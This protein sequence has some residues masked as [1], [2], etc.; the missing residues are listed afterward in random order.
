MNS[1]LVFITVLC[2]TPVVAQA[3]AVAELHSEYRAMGAGNFDAAAGKALWYKK[4]VN[5]KDKKRRGCTSCHTEDPRKEGRHV[6]TGKSIEPMAPSVNPKRLTD[7]KK[8]KKWLL[9]NCK[10]TMGRECTPQEKGDLLAFL[11]GL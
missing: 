3:D 11:K 7:V 4:F 8:I 9:R 2:L 6:R 5:P 10:W 1:R